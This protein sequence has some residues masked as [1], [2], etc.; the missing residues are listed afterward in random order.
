MD[1]C[2]Q[3]ENAIREGS[4]LHTIS[5]IEMKNIEVD[6]FFDFL[7]E[8]PWRRKQVKNLLFGYSRW[9]S[10][11]DFFRA[12]LLVNLKFLY[13][14][15]ENGVY[16]QYIQHLPRESVAP[17]MNSIEYVE[18]RAGSGF[19]DELLATGT[20]PRLTTLVLWLIAYDEG[21]EIY[22]DMDIDGEIVNYV[23]QNNQYLNVNI[24]SHFSQGIVDF[25]SL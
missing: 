3:W 15:R 21:D 11:G 12:D 13:L 6:T 25:N 7:E 16:N 2:R 5:I 19:V 24:I 23:N 18:D 8:G 9:P 1:V 4:L 22:R 14:S 17:F 10:A 20:C